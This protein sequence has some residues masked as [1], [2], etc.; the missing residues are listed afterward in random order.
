MKTVVFLLGVLLLFSC[1]KEVQ[2]ED[3][4]DINHGGFDPNERSISINIH[5]LNDIDTLNNNDL[6]HIK[7]EISANFMMHGYSLTISMGSEN[8]FESNQHIHGDYFEID[9]LWEHEIEQSNW[10]NIKLLAIGNHYG[11]LDNKKVWEIFVN[12]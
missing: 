6:L 5:S 1:E 4:Q 9:Y 10:I 12:I 2:N 7:G 11:S 8:L 3:S